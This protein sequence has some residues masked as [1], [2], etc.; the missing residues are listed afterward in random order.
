MSAKRD[1]PER[2]LLPSTAGGLLPATERKAP[3]KRAPAGL[4][5]HAPP[6]GSPATTRNANL[7]PPWKKGQSGNPSGYPA[8]YAD[9]IAAAR[10]HSG[11]ALARLAELMESDDE[12]VATVAA[13]TMLERAWGKAREFPDAPPVAPGRMPDLRRLTLKEQGIFTSLLDKAST[14]SSDPFPNR[15]QE[16]RKMLENSS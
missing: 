13:Q 1:R 12:R 8:R 7:R 5:L 14:E 15:F 11:R 4:P 16:Y 9:L 6:V 10:E 2:P 3:S